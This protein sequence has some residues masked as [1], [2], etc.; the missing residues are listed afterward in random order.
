M[1]KAAL[2]A[3]KKSDKPL[4]RWAE[5]AGFTAGAGQV[6]LV[7]SDK[8]G[9]ERVLFGLGDDPA[10]F[11]PGKLAT[12]LPAGTYALESGF[13]DPR[14]A[15]LAF[16][17]GSYRFERYRKQAKDGPRLVCPDG[18]DLA[19]VRRIAAGAALARDL[20]NTPANDMGPQE[21]EDAARGVA[22][23]HKARVKVIRGDALLKQNFP[24]IHAVGRASPREPRLIDI[25]WGKASAPKVTLVGKGIVFDTG[26][27][28]LKPSS[29][30]RLMKK[31][32]GGA[33]NMLGLA[34]MIMDAGLDVRLRVLIPSAENAVS[35]NAF[36]PSDILQSR[37]GITVE[38]GNTDAE[39]RLVLAD[40]LA[41]ADE[42]GPEIIVDLATLTGAARVALG[43]DL[44]A[45]FCHD[46]LLSAELMAAGAAENDP[47]W[48]LPL[49]GPY[50]RLLDSKVAD[51]CNISGGGF[52]GAITAALFMEKFVEKTKIWLHG[53]IFAWRPSAEPGRP[54]GGEAHA[55]RALFRVLSS[56]Y[57]VKS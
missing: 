6:L 24:M 4:F 19:E 8:G 28:D 9:L 5:A 45:V 3:L 49:Y 13:A 39:G 36:R 17:L 46:D 56:R 27:L 43:P 29:N 31:D 15:V 33:A 14:M 51:I 12:A 44:P 35:G 57:A 16:C 18:V 47:V 40:A 25:T 37:K 32:M 53:D 41:L 55:I 2:K 50:A 52:G 20:V 10:P 48:R 1:D 21:L 54:E 34:H 22:A 23:R 7:P 11:L 26:G 38:V 30:M 42:E